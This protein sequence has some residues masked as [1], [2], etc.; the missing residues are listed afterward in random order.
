[1]KKPHQFI[2]DSIV[3]SGY[4]DSALTYIYETAEGFK[5]EYPVVGLFD[6]VRNI[7]KRALDY[8]SKNS[9]VLDAG[10]G[11]G[12]ISTYLQNKGFHVIA[13]EKSKT[14]CDIL[15]KRNLKRVVNGDIFKYNPLEKYDTVL[16][17]YTW[18]ILGKSK[19]S[20]NEVFTSLN[21]KLLKKN[22]NV[23][24]VFRKQSLG[25]SPF[26]KRRFIFNNQK[27][28][29][30]K[31]YSFSPEKIIS[32]GKTKGWLVE[33]FYVNDSNHYFLIMKR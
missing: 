1:M 24:F 30:F 18:S 29:W 17:F 13:L 15:K 8:L 33:C 5:K 23:I 7:E 20:I 21:K 4:K 16:L 14:I 26:I 28:L 6:S 2:Y 25:K 22:G 10:A 3:D 31:S 12:R 9:K 32:I 19:G 11:A 27:S